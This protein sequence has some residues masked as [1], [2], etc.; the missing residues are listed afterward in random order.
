MPPTQHSVKG[1][2]STYELREEA[3][4]AISD[5]IVSR[6]TIDALEIVE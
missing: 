2:Y 6:T 1:R 4:G 3:L 5:A